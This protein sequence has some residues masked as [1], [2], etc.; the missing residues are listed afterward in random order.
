MKHDKKNDNGIVL[1]TLI[2]NIA[3]HQ[4]NCK[5]DNLL[6]TEALNFYNS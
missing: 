5:V 6:I 4:I 3:K 2:K 1:F